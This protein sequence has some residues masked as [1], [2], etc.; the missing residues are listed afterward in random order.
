MTAA[1]SLDLPEFDPADVTL[2]GDA[3]H[4]T[5]R[6]LAEQSWLARIPLGYLTLDREA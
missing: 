3:F 1:A 6:A 4:R 5:M 2:N